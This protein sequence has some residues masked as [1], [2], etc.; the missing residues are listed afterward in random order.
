MK[1]KLRYSLS[2][3]RHIYRHKVLA[4]FSRHKILRVFAVISMV[5]LGIVL[6]LMIV[7]RPAGTSQFK[8]LGSSFSIKYAQELGLDWK[9]TYLALLEDIDIPSLRLMSYWDEYEKENDVYDFETLDWQMDK[10]QENG[11]KVSLAIGLRQPRWPECH[12]P[13]WADN[14]AYDEWKQE[15]E[16]YIAVVVNRYKDHPALESYQLENEA[17]NQWFG[18]CNIQDRKVLRQR[19]TDELDLVKSLDSNTPVIMSLSD[20]HGFPLGGPTPDI[21]G[22]SIYRVVYNTQVIPFYLIYPTPVWYHRMRAQVID[23]VKDK[24]VLVHELQLEPWGP[25][26]TV[27]LSIEEQNRSMSPAQMYRNVDFA[28]Q[29]GLDEGYLWGAEWWYWRK[30]VKNDPTIWEVAKDIVNQVNTGQKFEKKIR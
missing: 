30:T 17:F 15:L 29:I 22:Y 7:F 1:K 14:L 24:P 20:Q 12:Q 28:R 27:E 3:A 4:F 10:A 21:Y 16:E 26:P 8:R 9:E 2:L 5:I 13:N 19:L 25:K 6:L 23:L 11:A 18:V